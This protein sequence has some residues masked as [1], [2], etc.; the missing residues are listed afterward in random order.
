[1]QATCHVRHSLLKGS[2]MGWQRLIWASLQGQ[3]TGSEWG[4]GREWSEV[5]WGEGDVWEWEEGMGIRRE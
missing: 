1:M 3:P 4:S 2:K 5:E